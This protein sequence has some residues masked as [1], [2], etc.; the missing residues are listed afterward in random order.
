MKKILIAWML[1]L[2]MVFAVACGTDKKKD[3]GIL[4]DPTADV[5]PDSSAVPD[6]NNN[7]GTA[8]DSGTAAPDNG[9]DILPDDNGAGEN[10]AGQNDASDPDATVIPEL[11]PSEQPDASANGEQAQK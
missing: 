4:P 10:G 7:N 2:V 3:D 9:N 8:P 6:G 11:V 1:L 5:I